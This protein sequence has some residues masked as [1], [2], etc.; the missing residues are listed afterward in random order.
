MKPRIRPHEFV[1]P[2]LTRIKNKFF[3]GKSTDLKFYPSYQAAL[4]ESGEGYENSDLINM[5]FLKSEIFSKELDRKPYPEI[6]STALHSLIAALAASRN[7]SR[8]SVID[9][10]GSFGVHYHIVRKCLGSSVSLDWKIVET[11]AVV[12]K[13]KQLE[14]DH[15]KFYDSI[16]DAVKAG[17]EIDLI[18]CSSG[19]QYSPDPYS[20]LQD[21]CDSRARMIL[22][23][24]MNMTR[25]NQDIITIQK[26][27]LSENGVGPAPANISDRWV[28]YPNTAIQKNKF[29]DILGRNYKIKIWF[30]D[31]TGLVPVN[32]EPLEGFGLLCELKQGGK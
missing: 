5:I 19:L 25:G 31:S 4:K 7:K 12:K 17:G 13:A 22:F 29:L 28:Q 26:S 2:I 14:T 9:F 32:K 15:L 21:M 8:I 11:A 24:R 18:H 1:P 16:G 23:C 30:E 27:M 20:V 10:A 6:R 3:P